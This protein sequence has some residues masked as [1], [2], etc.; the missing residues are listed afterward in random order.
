M[1]TWPVIW[2]LFAI[3]TGEPPMPLMA[4]A[5]QADCLAQS[6][7]HVDGIRPGTRLYCVRYTAWLAPSAE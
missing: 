6:N 2:M 4:M 5:T 1:P 7:G 3:T